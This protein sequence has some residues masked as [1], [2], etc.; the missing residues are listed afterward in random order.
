MIFS[1]SLGARAWEDTDPQY[2]LSVLQV[3]SKSQSI[4]CFFPMISS[5]TIS[6]FKPYFPCEHILSSW[7]HHAWI[8]GVRLWIPEYF[9]C[10]GFDWESKKDV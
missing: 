8:L 6:G 1:T 4:L 10:K 5:I 9:V 7:L 2:L 3:G